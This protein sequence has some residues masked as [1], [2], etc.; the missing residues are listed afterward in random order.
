MSDSLAPRVAIDLEAATPGPPEP[1]VTGL[2]GDCA[3]GSDRS[4][5]AGVSALALSLAFTLGFAP[6]EPTAVPPGGYWTLGESR[7]RETAPLDGEEAL[8]IGAVL[9]GLG[10]VRAGGGAVSVWMGSNPD[11]CPSSTEEGCKKFGNFGWF[12]VAEGGFMLVTGAVHLVIGGI[13]RRNYQRWKLRGSA[14][15]SAPN[16]HVAPW[17]NLPSQG[18]RAG[19]LRLQFRF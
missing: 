3:S 1:R 16:L 17:L 5:S 12:G 11:A 13:R 19:G 7:E 10:L 14:W 18:E 9:L 6:P 2:A 15:L 4:C 8:T